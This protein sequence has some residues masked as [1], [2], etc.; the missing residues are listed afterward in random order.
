MTGFFKKNLYK[1]DIFVFK[2]QKE[3]PFTIWF[4]GV[5]TF[6]VIAFVLCGGEIEISAFPPKIKVKMT[7]LIEAVINIK[8]VLA[9]KEREPEKGKDEHI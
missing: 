1:D 7:S 5:S 8:K 4:M 6:L 9:G 3:S 2:I